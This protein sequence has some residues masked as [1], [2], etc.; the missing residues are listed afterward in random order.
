MN[1]FSVEPGE[2]SAR[3]MSIQPERLASKKS[4]E[5][6]S[7]RISPVMASAS[8]IATETLGPSFCAAL[9][10]T[11]LQPL[12]HAALDG[13][14]R[15]ASSAG[16]VARAPS[17]RHAAASAGSA[18]RAAGHVVE[19]CARGL[20][21]AEQR[22]RSTMRASTR[23]RAASRG[24]RVAVG[25]ALLGQLRQRDEQRGFG[26]GQPPR[27]LAEIGERGGAHAF[28]VAAIGRERQVELE[29]LVLGEPRAR[30]GWR[31]RSGGA[32]CRGC[33]FRAA[34]S[35]GRPASTA[36]S[37]R[38]RCGRCATNWPAAR[39]SASTSTPSCSRKRWS[40]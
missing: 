21:L 5:P 31:E 6:T 34:R 18:R 15:G 4:A 10:A 29:D 14:P 11:R 37:R 30:S 26:D 13:E 38:R 23:S 24:L 7:A 40:S 33:G 1:G 9:C 2:R 19:R 8:T 36:S 27:L 17:R 12:L 32:S 3:V 16:C 39:S 22:R 28:E 35:A 25:P 20:A